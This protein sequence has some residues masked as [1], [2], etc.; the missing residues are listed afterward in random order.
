MGKKDHHLQQRDQQS[1]DDSRVEAVLQLLRKQAPLSVKQVELPHQL[2]DLHVLLHGFSKSLHF[3][4]GFFQPI[5]F[6]MDCVSFCFVLVLQEKF[7][8]TAC[9]ERF[10]KAKGDSVKKAAKQLRACLSWRQSIGT[11]SFL[12][13]LSHFF[14]LVLLIL[15][16]SASWFLFLFC[17]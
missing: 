12:L 2:S 9:V 4:H 1:K 16:F 17:V 10:L 7:C 15:F 11:G 14:L 6:L 13:L 3:V 8:N 5:I